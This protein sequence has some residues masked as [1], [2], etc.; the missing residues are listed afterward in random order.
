MKSITIK[1]DEMLFDK[2]TTL[3][4]ELHLSKSEL[5]RKAIRAY[6]EEMHKTKIKRKIQEA[7]FKVR[8]ALKEETKDLEDTYLDGLND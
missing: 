8:E 1:T 7:S 3:A 6:E 2:I 5:I 4:K